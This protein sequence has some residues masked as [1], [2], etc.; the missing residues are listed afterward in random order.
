LDENIQSNAALVE[1]SSAAAMSLKAQANLLNQET[2]KFIIDEQ[3]TEALVESTEE[4]FGVNL[5]TVRRDM[6]IWRTSVQTYLNGISIDMDRE[7]AVN[8]EAC[9]VGVALAKIIQGNPNIEAMSE[10][11]IAN[12]LHV[13]Q[14]QIVREALFIM[15]DKVKLSF[16]ELREKDVLLDDFVLVTNQLDQALSVLNN[17]ILR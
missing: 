2:N 16:T 12:D 7:K 8:H 5:S 6:R 1:E 3:K 15:N 13:K 17:A 4:I 14:H 11:I 9:S 10:Y